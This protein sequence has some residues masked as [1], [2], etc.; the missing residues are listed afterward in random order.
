MTDTVRVPRETIEE[1]ADDLRVISLELTKKRATTPVSEDIFRK[2]LALEALAASPHKEEAMT[3]FLA[4]LTEPQ[5]KAALDYR[6]PDTHPSQPGA[7]PGDLRERVA[8]LAWTYSCSS[9][10]F[11]PEADHGWS[12]AL[13][14]Y[15]NDP[16]YTRTRSSTDFVDRTWAF[17]DAIL[18][19]IQSERLNK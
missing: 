5:R 8:R 4:T 11:D 1:I 16:R 14:L 10:P 17:A 9:E 7:L 13:D 18:D 3:G 12:R 6:G 15:A 19:L 2:A